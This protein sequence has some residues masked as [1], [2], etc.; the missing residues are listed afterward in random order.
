M[1]LQIQQKFRGNHLFYVDGKKEFYL[2]EKRVNAD[3]LV[4]AGPCL[5][6]NWC[7]NL[8]YTLKVPLQ[9]AFESL[10]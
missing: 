7:I 2:N 8:Y 5:G 1:A 9:C 4:V 6:I 3:F 10:A